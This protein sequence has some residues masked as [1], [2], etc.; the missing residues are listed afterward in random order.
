MLGMKNH[1]D[2][3]GGIEIHKVNIAGVACLYCFKYYS[4]FN[5][6]KK[7]KRAGKK[8]IIFIHKK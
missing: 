6:I 2:I 1:F 7:A 4:F 5:N 3:S 8:I